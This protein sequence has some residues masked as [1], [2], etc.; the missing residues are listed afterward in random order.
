MNRLTRGGVSFTYANDSNQL[1]AISSP[2]T[3]VVHDARGNVT[4]KDGATG[5]DILFT[6]DL[7]NRLR[8]YETSPATDVW[9]YNYD[10]FGRRV[11]K[12]KSGEAHYY[13]YDGERVVV[14]LVDTGTTA[15][16][17]YMYGN[18]IDEVLVERLPDGGSTGTFWPLADSLG[19]VRDL[20]E[21]TGSV[22][23]SRMTYDI[24]PDGKLVSE[25]A[26]G[27][28][29]SVSQDVLFTG[30][31]LDRESLLYYYRA[32]HY[33]PEIGRFLQSD[34]IGT[35]KDPVNL[36]NGYGY[37]GND[38]NNHRDPKGRHIE[39]APPGGAGAFPE[40]E[41]RSDPGDPGD[42]PED[43][44][45]DGL[46]EV[47]EPREDGGEDGGENNGGGPGNEP[48]DDVGDVLE[49]IGIA[50]LAIVGIEYH[51]IFPECLRVECEEYGIDIDDWTVPMGTAQHDEIHDGTEGGPWV[52]DVKVILDD[53]PPFDEFIEEVIELMEEY[54]IDGPLVPYP[55]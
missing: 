12:S 41:A 50:A 34:P 24:D 16:K 1:T 35:W 31:T 4:T 20:G 19:T 23:R 54:G 29:S 48:V 3:T 49:C 47:C 10:A 28:T 5:T 25:A 36:G 14:E 33:D 53:D 9:T 13:F 44:E 52:D 21:W 46:G 11:K 45:G 17:E 27:G 22:A 55:R 7:L 30:R 37:V 38:P 43:G 15:I 2:S 39:P 42:F 40:A 51:H 6:H 18:A 8:K 32:R 26:A